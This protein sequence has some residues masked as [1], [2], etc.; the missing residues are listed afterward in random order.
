MDK[1][2]TINF[3]TMTA[4][5]LNHNL[6]YPNRFKTPNTNDQNHFTGECVI[7]YY[8]EFGICDFST[9]LQPRNEICTISLSG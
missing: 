2:L 7:S 1:K 5:I 8:L 6:Q 9:G 4:E 3:S